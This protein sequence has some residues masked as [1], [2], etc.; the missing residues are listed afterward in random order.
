MFMM[1]A[2]NSAYLPN[3]TV[4]SGY[5]M[6]PALVKTSWKAKMP[7]SSSLRDFIGFVIRTARI[8]MTKVTMAKAAKDQII[9]SKCPE[10]VSSRCMLLK[11]I[12]GTVT[13]KTNPFRYLDASKGTSLAFVVKRPMATKRNMLNIF[14]KMSSNMASL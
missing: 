6:K 7:L 5:P 3:N 2:K 11:I 13:F 1:M 8:A 10:L 4:V 9:S 14:N 12:H